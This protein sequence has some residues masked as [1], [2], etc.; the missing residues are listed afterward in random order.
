VGAW[1]GTWVDLAGNNRQERP[2][3][4]EVKMGEDPHA[5]WRSDTRELLD[6]TFIGANPGVRAQIGDVSLK[7]DVL[8]FS[9]LM[10]DVKVNCQLFL[11]A[12]GEYKGDCVG[13]ATNFKR[14]VTLA[15]PEQSAEQ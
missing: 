4:I 1:S 6:G 9:F 8:S 7:D 3:S 15:P 10:D 12:E 2:V 5:R 14:T 11:N 13:P